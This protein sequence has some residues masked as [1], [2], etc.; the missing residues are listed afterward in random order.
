MKSKQ[1]YIRAALAFIGINLFAAFMA[2]LSGFNFDQR[3]E[4]VGL[5]AGVFFL[6]STIISGMILNDGL[7]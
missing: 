4:F 3:N 7:L 5:Y 1:K 2:W 6:L